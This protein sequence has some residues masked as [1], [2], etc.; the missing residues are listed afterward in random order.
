MLHSFSKKQDN[1]NDE[2]IKC[3]LNNVTGTEP[4]RYFALKDETKW[5]L[6]DMNEH[7]EYI[8]VILNTILLG[9]NQETLI[10]ATLS[11]FWLTG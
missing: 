9:S 6:E 1:F 5:L 8:T 7:R 2:N 4:T 11:Q 3:V 10:G